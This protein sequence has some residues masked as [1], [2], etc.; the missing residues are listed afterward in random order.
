[1]LPVT[2]HHISHISYA[3]AVHQN[4]SCGNSAVYPRPPLVHLQDVAG[5]QYK[6]I[7]FINPQAL[8]NLRLRLQM[9]DFS[10]YWNRIFRT[11]QRIEQLDLFLTGM[12]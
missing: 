4:R 9:L 7:L 3:E 1:M 11:D 5:R 6:Y 10:M 12:P 2:Q 8:G